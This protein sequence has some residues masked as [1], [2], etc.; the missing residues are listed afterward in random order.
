MLAQGRDELICDLAET[1]GVLDYRAL[2]VPL[3]ATLAEG[4]GASSRIRRRLS[5]IPAPLETLLQAAMADHLAFLS[6]AQTRDA[7]KGRNRPESILKRL[8]G[9]SEKEVQGFATAEDFEAARQ[10]ILSGT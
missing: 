2:P 9:E 4:L 5:G 1:Y 10:K 7:Q 6:W 8:Y 3:L